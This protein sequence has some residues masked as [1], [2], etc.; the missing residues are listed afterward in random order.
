[1]PTEFFAIVHRQATDLAHKWP[2][3]HDDRHGDCIGFLAVKRVHQQVSALTFD[4]SQQKTLM[5]CAFNQ[6]DFPV[7]IIKALLHN[8]RTFFYADAVLYSSAPILPFESL[9]ALLSALAQVFVE[10]APAAMVS[11]NMLVNT[12]MADSRLALATHHTRDLLRTQVISQICLNL[13][14]ITGVNLIRLRLE[15][16]RS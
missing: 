1:M 3:F 13:A 6:I 16:R 11:I 10:A 8:R 7:S 15:K 5:A 9:S 14:C 12:F 4:Q 2:Q